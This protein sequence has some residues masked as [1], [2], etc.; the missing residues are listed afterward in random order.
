MRRFL[1]V[2]FGLKPKTTKP[3]PDQP[4]ESL[5]EYIR[6]LEDDYYPWY[7]KASRR[8]KYL[9]MIAQVTVIVVGFAT[10]IVAALANDL[11]LVSI[12]MPRLLLI[13]LP[14]ISSFAA[15]VLVQARLLERK[16][17]RER[18]RQTIQGLIAR[19]KVD[20]AQAKTDESLSEIHKKLIKAVQDLEERQALEAGSLFSRSNKD[21]QPG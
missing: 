8:N 4:R 2:V 11:S 20:F 6:E 19:A 7:D 21:G 16:M 9:W 12:T 18:G 5:E 10:A 13:I 1:R 14:I 15:T 17:L 3:L